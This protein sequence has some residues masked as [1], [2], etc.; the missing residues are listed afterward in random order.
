M[1][2][3]PLIIAQISDLH[4]RR[5]GELS[6]GIVDTCAMLRIC[7]AQILAMPCRPALLL[8]SGDLVDSGTP[9]EYTAL[10]ELLRPLTMPC[11]LIPGNHDD[12]EVL[13]R[14]FADH[15]GLGQWPPFV[16]YVIEEWPLRIIALDT[17]IP[18]E[19]GGRLCQERLAWLDT[20]LAAK[21]GKPALVMMHHPPIRSGIAGMDRHGLESSA[22]FEAV[23]A[24]HPQVARIVCGHLHRHIEAR[25][26]GVPVSV[27]PS[28]AHQIALDLDPASRARFVMEPPGFL[29]HFW[30]EGEGIVTHSVP[31]GAFAGPYGFEGQS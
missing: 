1:S 28:P 2:M 22:A 27:C 5:E 21:P 9:E 17:V 16:Q 20:T 7:V 23:I 18:G 14:E 30:N 12:R 10:R 24:K 15:P 6:Y 25:V 26:G 8:A 13:R 19:D 31:V 29:L 11:Y 3:R 4:V